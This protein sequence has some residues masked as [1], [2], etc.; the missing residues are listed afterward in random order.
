MADLH[1]KLWTEQQTWLE[2]LPPDLTI[3]LLF[4]VFTP[5]EIAAHISDDLEALK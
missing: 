2:K 1:E 4:G 5:G 3:P